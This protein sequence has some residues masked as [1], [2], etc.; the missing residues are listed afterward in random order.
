MSYR[1]PRLVV[2]TR[3]GDAFVD[4]VKDVE[5]SITQTTVNYAQIARKNKEKNFE[6]RKK[7]NQY[8]SDIDKNLAK[9]A[10]KN[11]MDYQSLIGGVQGTVDN[12]AQ[13]KMRYNAATDYYEG[14]E[15]DEALIKSTEMFLSVGLEQQLGATSSIFESYDKFILN[16]GMDGKGGAVSSIGMDPKFQVFIDAQ[17]P[18]NNVD[19]KIRYEIVDK[20]VLY[21][22]EGKAIEELNKAN[23]IEGDSYTISS[24]NLLNQT[25]ADGASPYNYGVF[26]VIPSMMGGDVEGEANM[27]KSLQEEGILGR[28]GNFTKDYVKDYGT[29]MK[30]EQID[31][32][33]KVPVIANKRAVD[34]DA[35]SA[36]LQTSTN[37]RVNTLL[38]FR[39]DE[40]YDYV[41]TNSKKIEKDGETYF[42][43]RP[44][45]G[46]DEN[47]DVK[48]G[49]EI[50]ISENELANRNYREF[51][52]TGYSEDVINAVQ[53][54]GL[55]DALKRTG[56]LNAP[57]ET[58][59]AAPQSMQP[60]ARS[61]EANLVSNV[62][63]SNYDLLA[64]GDIDEVDFSILNGLKGY[65]YEQAPDD[66][67]TLLVYDK[68]G[69]EGRK[70]LQ[71]IDLRK[72]S[73]A[74]RKLLNIID[75]EA[76]GIINPQAKMKLPSVVT[77]LTDPVKNFKDNITEE[78][79]MGSLSD[80]YLKKMSQL[81]IDLEETSIGSDV[82]LMT[83][84]NGQEV[85]IDLEEDGWKD[86]FE[87]N[88][89]GAILM[90]PSYKQFISQPKKQEGGESGK[91]T[92]DLLSF[93]NKLKQSESSND[94][95]ASRVNKSGERYVGELQFGEARL[96]DYKNSTG[97]SFDLD[98]FQ[99]SPSLQAKVG[100]WHIGDID[101]YIDQ[102][103]DLAKGYDRDGLRA[104]AHLGG[105]EGMKKWLE[106][107]GKA[108]PSDELGTS[109]TK[110]YNKFSK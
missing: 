8:E 86:E 25:L 45:E 60:K 22:T 16:N 28:D 66:Q 77:D 62:I 73:D 47:G 64:G 78:N 91:P 96:S 61:E 19:A 65:Q 49:E 89:R 109:L 9:V 29:Y 74:E 11:N 43:H 5:Q 2:D 32:Y 24:K 18:N 21:I 104:I 44:V 23:G 88:M 54:I 98:E 1:N 36:M 57:L 103:G 94:T 82:I 79:F 34:I 70:V 39:G 17:K 20:D 100:L 30:S 85:E 76:K 92:L 10:V 87:K 83:K 69:K 63:S 51:G 35:A 48:R 3:L 27:T 50:L 80:D 71:E 106:S 56:A 41:R 13:S 15:E 95:T 7:I 37:A 99:G 107:K 105:K 84:P 4:Y 38:G 26:T 55:D 72:S 6:L 12:L 33:G 58:T 102:L 40:I 42:S 14:M 101:R 75:P 31:G 67:F 52:K 59:K 81:G 93:Y 97:A 90:S 46:R 53:K 110:Y 68:P 108:N